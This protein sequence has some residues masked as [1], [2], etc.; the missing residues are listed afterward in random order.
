VDGGLKEIVCM[1]VHDPMREVHE[2]SEG[3]FASVIPPPE[4]PS[5]RC[6]SAVEETIVHLPHVNCQPFGLGTTRFRVVQ[7]GA[8]RERLEVVRPYLA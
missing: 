6:A 7:Q 5:A 8:R 1:V 3:P 4:A 2:L